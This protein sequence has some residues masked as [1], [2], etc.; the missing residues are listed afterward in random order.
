MRAVAFVF[1]AT[2][3][4]SAFL[5]FQV[6]L[7]V[8]KYILPWFGGSAAVWTTSMLVFQVL[9]LAGY[10]YSHLLSQRLSS[11]AQ[12]RLHLGLLGASLLLVLALSLWWPSAITPGASWKPASTANPALRVT[13]ILLVAAG[14]PF[15]VLSTTGPLLQKWFAQYGNDAR[16][17]RLYSVSNL[18][19]LLGLL[20]FPFLLEPSLAISTQG[21][22][23]ALLFAAFVLACAWCAWRSGNSTGNAGVEE[24]LDSAQY[25]TTTVGV[26]ILWFLLP[27][28]ASALLLSTTNLLCQEITSIPLLW[29]LPLALYLLS[30]ILCFDH[31]RWYRRGIFHPLFALGLFATVAVI[32]FVQ[33]TSEVLLLPIL[34]FVTCMICHGELVRLKPKVS[35]LTSFY[36]AISSG[37]A[38][39]GVFVA[40]IAPR[41][42]HFFI[43]FQI[44][45]AVSIVLLLWCL[46]R[47]RQSWYHRIGLSWT[48]A[49][50]AGIFAAVYAGSFWLPQ[51]STLL[52]KWKFYAVALVISTLVLLGAY[53]QRPTLRPEGGGFRA[54][55]VLIGLL[56]ILALAGLYETAIPH[57]SLVLS[58][59][60]FYG[61]LRVYELPRG[62]KILMHGQTV[63]GAQLDPPNQHV[64][65]VYYGPDSGVGILLQNHPKRGRGESLR[66]GVVGMG[67]GTLAAYGR[68]GDIIRFYEIN[69]DVVELTAGSTPV[70]TYIRDSQAQVETELG[71]ARLLLERELE[72]REPQ[73]FDVLVLDAFS[74]D[75]VPVHLLTKEAFATY[76]KHVNAENGVI[77]IHVSSRHINLMPVLE[78]IARQYQTPMLARFV[79]T[80]YPFM[81]NLWVILARRPEDLQVRGLVA[82]P[83]PL[84]TNVAPRLWT[85]DYSDIFRL[86]Y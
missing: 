71:D 25:V 12:T 66:V 18:G 61:A 83:P 85:D 76:W 35:K 14:L 64:P 73:G 55:H 2:S 75:A 41:I 36:L 38:L 53:M 34:L 27:A 48:A 5:L 62:G 84:P 7:I 31:P 59:R 17:Y 28:C 46:L 39:G 32:H 29:V 57:Q 79:Y 8:S 72:N 67:A 81:N 22:L 60:N 26:R 49:L 13:G 54:G 51:L 77:A 56:T 40:L 15:F 52:D 33:V 65:M 37:G 82:Y 45:L 1:A 19:S 4:V 44:S 47:D 50:V 63:H 74:G 78:G 43:E 58:K 11:R 42:F 69:P 20:S 6:Q 3:F 9:L 80:E 24:E 68:P 23:W 30:F 86:L 16:T 70:F 10:C 21:K